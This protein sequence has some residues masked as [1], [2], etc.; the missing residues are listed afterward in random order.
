V[1]LS[2]PRPYG[3]GIT[4]PGL[5][6]QRAALIAIDGFG[7]AGKTTIAEKLAEL[8]GSARIVHMDD[9]LIDKTI[10]NTPELLG[11]D[12]AGIASTILKPI[13]SK[14]VAP[15]EDFIIIEGI[16]ALHQDFR[17]NFDYGIWI[18]TSIDE[19]VK[20]A[21]LRDSGRGNEHLRDMWAKNDLAYFEVHRPDL[22]AHI[23]IKN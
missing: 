17:A 5:N 15:E 22:A 8:L 6:Q 12:R 20:R 4:V 13:S 1:G 19:S 2:I 9:H 23:V 21:V 10:N 18:G 14:E 16:S 11:F 7:G 3:R